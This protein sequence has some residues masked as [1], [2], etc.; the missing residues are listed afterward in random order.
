MSGRPLDRSAD[1]APELAIVVD[2]EEEF[3]WTK[4]FDRACT[5]TTSIPA[6]ARAHELYDRLGIRPTYVVDYPVATNPQSAAFLRAL[7]EEGRAEIGAHLHAWVTPPHDEQ[8]TTRNSYQGNLPPGLEQAKI[9]RLTDAV[10][11]AVGARPTIF[12]AGRHGFGP[13]TARHLV[14]LGYTID[15]SLL[16]HHD[17]GGDGGPDFTRAS[18]QPHWLASAP[19][20]LEIPVTTGFFGRAAGLGPHLKGLFDNP[21]AARLHLP[22]MLARAGLVARSR[23][24]PEGISAAEQR[25]LLQRLVAR[26]RRTFCLVYHSPSLAP[27]H[28]PYVRTPEDLT[29]FLE[30]IE[31]TLTFFRDSLGGRFTTLT[32][33]HARMSAERAAG[34]VAM[35]PATS[36]TAWRA[37]SYRDAAGAA[38]RVA[39]G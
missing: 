37:G 5:A 27:G 36:P 24:S 4:P 34:L 25:R 39:R 18:D 14:S 35:P 13:E 2:T 28:T 3:D 11:E 32:Q 12:K 29:L 10:E 30:R 16:P 22:G 9:A 19:D 26:G 21:A 1:L 15:C 20:L 7:R 17:L 8:V 6:Q 31:D 23:L 33:V 38:G